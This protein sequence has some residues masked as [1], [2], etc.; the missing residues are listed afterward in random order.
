MIPLAIIAPNGGPIRFEHVSFEYPSR[1][2][3]IILKH[4]DLEV[5]VGESVAI[6][7]VVVIMLFF[8]FLGCLTSSVVIAKIFQLEDRVEVGSLPS[9][10]F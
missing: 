10:H 9:M 6:V 5:G 2:N 8:S 7:W 1:K 4:L 3:A